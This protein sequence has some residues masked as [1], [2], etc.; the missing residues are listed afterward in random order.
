MMIHDDAFRLFVAV[1]AAHRLDDFVMGVSSTHR[2]IT[3]RHATHEPTRLQTPK[4][5][6]HILIGLFIRT[7]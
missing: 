7:P 4:N 2:S 6:N 5:S 3:V 1:G